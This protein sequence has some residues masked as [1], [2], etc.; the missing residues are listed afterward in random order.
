MRISQSTPSTQDIVFV[1][2]IER[3]IPAILEVQA[4]A[5]RL[6][7][8][9]QLPTRVIWVQS[10]R[11]IYSHLSFT[12]RTMRSLALAR[13]YRPALSEGRNAHVTFRQG[14]SS[15]PSVLPRLYQAGLSLIEPSEALEG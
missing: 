10:L 1:G 13:S 14:E 15:A 6:C 12:V 8:E 2:S 7:F 4:R 11:L 3:C 9:S 5:A